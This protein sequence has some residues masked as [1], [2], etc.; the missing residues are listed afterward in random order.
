M[1]FFNIIIILSFVY[2]SYLLFGS[3]FNLIGGIFESIYLISYFIEKRILDYLGNDYT[4]FTFGLFA[5]FYSVN[6]LKKF[7]SINS[8]IFNFKNKIIKKLIR[9]STIA[10]K[11]NNDYLI[12]KLND[13][14]DYDVSKTLNELGD[15]VKYLVE[16]IKLINFKDFYP[17][18]NCKKLLPELNIKKDGYADINAEDILNLLEINSPKN[19]NNNNSNGNNINIDNQ[20]SRSQLINKVFNNPK[21]NIKKIIRNLQLIEKND[22]E[23]LYLELNNIFIDYFYLKN[24]KKCTKKYIL[25]QYNKGFSAFVEVLKK[26][27]FK[28][29]Y[30]NDNVKEIFPELNINEKGYPELNINDLIDQ[31]DISLEYY[32]KSSLINDFNKIFNDVV[33]NKNFSLYSIKEKIFKL[34]ESSILKVRTK[35]VDL[36][37]LQNNL[38]KILS[39]YSKETKELM[40]MIH[41]VNF[42]ETY[43]DKPNYREKIPQLNIN[44]EGHAQINIKDIL[45]INENEIYQEIHNKNNK[46]LNLNDINNALSNLE[47]SNQRS[48]YLE[49]RDYFVYLNEEDFNHPKL[50]MDKFNSEIESLIEKIKTIN[51]NDYYQGSIACTIFPE[52][53]INKEGYSTLNTT[54]VLKGFNITEEQVRNN[55]YDFE[56]YYKNMNELNSE[57][58]V[59]DLLTKIEISGYLDKKEYGT[60]LLSYLKSTNVLKLNLI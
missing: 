39:S 47:N 43:S 54:E 6:Y 58:K 2:T 3:V 13:E 29:L 57:F 25:N 52:L 59:N 1:N 5:L 50:F 60:F 28:K 19:N 33:N 44:K 12:L 9:L 27:N 4:L 17:Q 46:L 7:S 18:K 15:I 22:Q 36:I 21:F 11:S 41:N 55:D 16:V 10:F 14:F 35:L 38:D 34:N 31:L 53:K 37:K 26:K 56:T 45:G 49:L 24:F 51:F 30:P 48:L 8:F 23:L 20:L 40:N 42:N 32:S